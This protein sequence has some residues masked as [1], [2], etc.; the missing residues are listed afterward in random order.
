M[1]RTLK[2][3]FGALV[4]PPPA[5]DGQAAEH[6]L[7]L[8]AA[9][10]LV[11]VMRADA[12]FAPAERQA[13]IAALRRKFALGDD[14]TERLVEL[15]AATAREATGFY[16]FTSHINAHFDMAAKIRMVEAMWGVAFADGHLSEHE[17]H[18]L[19]RVAD[20][21]HV[22]QG[23]YVHARLRAKEAADAARGNDGPPPAGA[24]GVP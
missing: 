18:T 1:L 14:E 15:A 23:A 11:E 8:A 4:P 7:Q 16:T 17:R 12:H 20:L 22:P 21:L 9:V 3:L 24:S 6:T 2:E 13:V 10:M 5:A 19:W